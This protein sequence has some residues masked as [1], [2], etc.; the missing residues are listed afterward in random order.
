MNHFDAR[1]MA[2]LTRELARIR[3][4]AYEIK[5]PTLKGRELVPIDNTS[6]PGQESVITRVMEMVG[7]AKIMRVPANDLPKADVVLSES[8]QGVVSLANFYEWNL[9]EVRAAMMAGRPLKDLRA[10]AARRAMENTLDELL[11]QGNAGFGLAGLFNLSGTL[12][13]APR[14]GASGLTSWVDADGFPAKTGRE[15]VAELNALVDRVWLNSD[16]VLAADTVILPNSFRAAMQNTYMGDG[17]ALNALQYFIAQSEY[18]SRVE[19]SSKLETAGAGGVPRI[20]AYARDP[21]YLEAIIPQD[22]EQLEPQ[23]VGFETKVICHMRYGGI[24]LKQP[25]AVVYMDFTP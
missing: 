5:F 1:E 4:L 2:F 6:A 24:D 19:R 9:Q 13:Q 3:P 8:F 12:T 11:L 20:I 10:T 23:T 21:E 18:V 15:M 14:E 7:D 22:F 25:G 17:I 16:E